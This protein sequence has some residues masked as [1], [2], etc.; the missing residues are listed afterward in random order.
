[1]RIAHVIGTV[2]AR[3]GGPAAAVWRLATAV[4]NAGHEAEIFTTDWDGSNRL[5]VPT[6]S[7][8]T[9]STTGVGVTYS[10]VHF[11][12][13]WRASVGLGLQLWR[14][15][16]DFDVVHVHGLYQFPVMATDLIARMKGVPL[17]VR[18]HGI[19]TD[20]HRKQKTIRKDVYELLFD[21]RMLARA[22]AVHFTSTEE[23]DQFYALGY[24]GTGFVVSLPVSW[25][26]QPDTKGLPGVE[27]FVLYF[28]RITIKKQL[29]LLLEAIALMRSR[30]TSCN[31]IIAG[32]D[33]EGLGRRLDARAL[34]LGIAHQVTR[35]GTLTKGQLRSLIPRAA[36]VAVPSR[37][38]NFC[39]SAA[40]AM[41]LGVPVIVTPQVGLHRMV[42][43]SGAGL[44]VHPTAG[45]LA[46]ALERLVI[47][48]DFRAQAGRRAAL[49][50]AEYFAPSRV[51]NQLIHHYQQAVDSARFPR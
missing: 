43:R 33:D 16:D 17:I 15:L 13:G 4:I 8:V 19:L 48:R 37:E 23:M 46:D 29:H 25:S 20:F 27:N 49:A 31:L 47:D 32:P 45:R 28:G 2:A 10:N 26:E 11:P 36:V 5:N 6:G 51:A 22:A 24:A 21:K 9:D 39:V 35:L 41:S 44:V 38:E 42:E 40:E 50:A 30:G 3:Y 1:M 12:R 7:R 34:Q 14:R 18:P